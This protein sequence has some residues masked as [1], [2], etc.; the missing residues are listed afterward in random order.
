[1]E[2]ISSSSS[3]AEW[4]VEDVSDK[5]R[6]TYNVEIANKFEGKH[7]S[8]FVNRFSGLLALYFPAD[9]F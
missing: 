3:V 7:N 1:M 9:T 2:D 4:T 6:E 8:L 5:I